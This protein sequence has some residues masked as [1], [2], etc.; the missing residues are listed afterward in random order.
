M[1][2]STDFIFD[3]EDGPYTEESV[4]NPVNYY[5]WSKL[6]A[7]KLLQESDIKWAIV[8]TVLVF[9]I[10]NDMSRSNIIYGSKILGGR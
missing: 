3:G 5:G 6:E 1:H 9:G 2:L 8:R 10:A 4:P 7:E